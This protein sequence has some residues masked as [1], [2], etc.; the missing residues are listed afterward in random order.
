MRRGW[1][2]GAVVVVLYIGGYLVYRVTHVQVWQVDDRAYVMFGSR[3]AWYLLRPVSRLDAAAT[4]MR[5]HLGPH[6]PPPETARQ[7]VDRAMVAA[8]GAERLAALKAFEWRGRAEAAIGGRAPLHLS[9]TWRLQ[10]PDS[11]I[12]T[13]TIEGQAPTTARS[14]IISGRRGWS[15]TGRKLTPLTAELV[16]HERDQFYLYHLMRLVPLRGSAYRLS[17]P[18]T[19]SLGRKRIRVS[20]AGRPSVDLAFDAAAN[21][22]GLTDS[23]TD[24]QSH[25]AVRQEVRLTGQLSVAGVRW[26]RRIAITWDGKPYFDLE[27]LDVRPLAGLVDPSLGGPAPASPRRAGKRAPSSRARKH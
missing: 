21:L 25:R 1:L 27:I 9:G 16:A 6:R 3:V 24:P 22:T 13:T 10:L 26:P 4:G 15:R 17:A 7:L 2:L 19:D 8:G 23:V 11:A 12:V 18:A 20:H 14:L 5:F